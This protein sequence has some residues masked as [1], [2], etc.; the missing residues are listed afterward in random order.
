MIRH[1]AGFFHTTSEI[2]IQA[3]LLK[4][5]LT[6]IIT[7]MNCSAAIIKCREY[8]FCVLLFLLFNSS[9]IYVSGAGNNRLQKLGSTQ[10]L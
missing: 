10:Y 1:S 3:N 6:L 2:K 4:T 7:L 8:G 9:T 5:K